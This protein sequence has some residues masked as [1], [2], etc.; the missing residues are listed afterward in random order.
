M[1]TASQDT[2]VRMWTWDGHFV[3]TCGAC[4]AEEKYDILSPSKTVHTDVTHSTKGGFDIRL[5]TSSSLP[6]PSLRPFLPPF[7]PSPSVLRQKAVSIPLPLLRPPVL[8]PLRTPL[9]LHPFFP[10]SLPPSFPLLPKGSFNILPLTLSFL[11]SSTSSP[12]L[13]FSLLPF[14]LP[15]SLPLFLPSLMF[16]VSIHLSVQSFVHSSIYSSPG[17]P[18]IQGPLASPRCG[19]FDSQSR[20]STRWGRMTCWSTPTLCRNTPSSQRRTASTS[21][22][23]QTPTATTKTRYCRRPSRLEVVLKKNWENGEPNSASRQVGWHPHDH[24]TTL[25]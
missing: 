24:F 2:T 23:I 22:V 21:W 1:L 11:S 6:S 15:S 17:P 25:D 19:T 18:L 13:P 12:H 3:G 4:T 20:T 14:F 9:P 10:P 5:L 16:C 7:L 8:L